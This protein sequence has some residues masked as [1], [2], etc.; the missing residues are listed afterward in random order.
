M[1]FISF[2]ISETKIAS[3][4][5]HSPSADCG[6]LKG[7]FP[8][9]PPTRTLKIDSIVQAVF[10]EINGNQ[11]QGGGHIDKSNIDHGICPRPVC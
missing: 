3:Q 1:F 5:G 2:S 6:F 11:F 7:T 9:S 10:R 8:Y 4:S